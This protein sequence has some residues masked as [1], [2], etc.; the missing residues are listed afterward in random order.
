MENL[1]SSS[2]SDQADHEGGVG[3]NAASNSSANSG[4]VGSNT[5]ASISSTLAAVPTNEPP[6]IQTDMLGVPAAGHAVETQARETDRAPDGTLFGGPARLVFG[7]SNPFQVISPPTIGAGSIAMSATTPLGVTA[8]TSQPI[9]PAL[10]LL[11]GGSTSSSIANFANISAE[12]LVHRL[13]QKIQALDVEAWKALDFDGPTILE[14]SSPALLPGQLTEYF[15]Y[16]GL[17]RDRVASAIKLMIINDESVVIDIRK[18]WG[19]Y[20]QPLLLTWVLTPMLPS[21][22][23]AQPPQVMSSTCLRAVDREPRH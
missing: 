10:Q 6:F 18:F 17:L 20:F 23:E 9:A 22:L 12:Q 21:S 4:D 3:G 16:S 2:S 19:L 13:R 1:S 8:P 5:V 11:S 15:G 7:F 14:L